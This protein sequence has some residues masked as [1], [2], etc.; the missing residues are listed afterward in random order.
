MLVITVA[1]N[2]AFK[3]KPVFL[4]QQQFD[5]K[6][7]ACSLHSFHVKL[8]GSYEFLFF[9]KERRTLATQHI[10]FFSGLIYSP[11]STHV[12]EGRWRGVTELRIRAHELRGGLCSRHLQP[13][14]CSNPIRPD[15]S[16]CVT[17]TV[18]L[19]PRQVSKIDMIVFILITV[20]ILTVQLMPP[21][22]SKKKHHSV[23]S[24]YS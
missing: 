17:F 20:L 24:F 23:Y 6:H 1:T 16:W 14:S 9:L 15:S 21:Q 12:P 3:K 13:S 10:K 22:I 19:L 4:N 5:R 7:N 18:Q 11:K 2:N 8:C